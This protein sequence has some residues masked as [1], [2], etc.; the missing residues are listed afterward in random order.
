MR[1]STSLSLGPAIALAAGLF[2][3]GLGGCTPADAPKSADLAGPATSASPVAALARLGRRTD[4]AVADSVPGW[5]SVSPT[6]SNPGPGAN[7]DGVMGTSG[8]IDL[9]GDGTPEVIQARLGGATWSEFTVFA[10]AEPGAAVLFTGD[11]SDFL[12]SRDRDVNGW[13]VL[14]TLGR[15]YDAADIGATKV[16]PE[17]VWNGARYAVATPAKP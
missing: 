7:P 12:V 13:P 4:V 1:R 3:A 16:S 14:A 11:G 15:D 5:L 9:N 10:S 17:Q 8:H 6:G 2:A